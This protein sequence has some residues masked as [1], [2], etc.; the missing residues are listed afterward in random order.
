MKNVHQTK[1]KSTKRDIV[2][3]ELERLVAKHGS[4]TSE[5]VLQEASSPKH[6]LHG[7]FEWDDAAAAAK[8]RIEQAYRMIQSSRFVVFLRTEGAPPQ[9]APVRQ[10]MRGLIPGAAGE[11]FKFRKQVLSEAEQRASFVERK[12][13]ELEGWCS[14]VVDVEEFG[15]LRAQILNALH[16][17]ES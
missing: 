9:A 14:S 6:P 2:E 5:L 12:K 13:R 4:I 3:A 1:A 15:T 11:G 16:E 8:F 10:S 17:T 7:F